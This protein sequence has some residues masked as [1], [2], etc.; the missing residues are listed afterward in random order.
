MIENLWSPWFL[1]K[2]QNFSVL[3][4]CHAVGF[5]DHASFSKLFKKHFGESPAEYSCQ[6]QE[7]TNCF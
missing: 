5:S 4:V 2:T 7:F 6:I 1:L 3:E